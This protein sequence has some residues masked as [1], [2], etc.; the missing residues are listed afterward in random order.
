MASGV[1]ATLSDLPTVPTLAD[2]KAMD[3]RPAS[4]DVAGFAEPGDGYEGTFQWFA[5]DTSPADDVLTIEFPDGRYKRMLGHEGSVDPVWWIAAGLSPGAAMPAALATGNSVEVPAG[6]FKITASIVLS[7]PGQMFRGQ[8]ADTILE[9]EGDFDLF[10][11]T[12]NVEGCEVGDFRID[13]AD[14]S[15]GYLFAIRTAHRVLVENIEGYVGWSGLYVEGANFTTFREV[16]IFGLFGE[17]MIQ[18]Y[19]TPTLRSDVI[20]FDNVVISAMPFI[21]PEERPWGF[22]H[23]GNVHTVD[24]DALRMVNPRR[25]V[26][27]RATAPGTSVNDGTAPSFWAV[28]NVQ[29]DFPTY[30]GFYAEIGWALKI[31]SSYFSNSLMTENVYV[32]PGVLMGSLI[33]GD[34][35]GAAK[36]GIVIGAKDFQILGVTVAGNSWGPGSYGKHA[37]VR[38]VGSARRVSFAG[39]KSGRYDTVGA[40][41]SIGLDIELGAEEIKWVGGNLA[42]NLVPWRDRSGNDTNSIDAAGSKHSLIQGV[43]IS[44]E[45]GLGA[46][47]EPVVTGGAIPTVNVTYGGLK[48]D[49]A[50]PPVPFAMDFSAEPGAGWA[51]HVVIS[52]AGVITAVVTDTPGEGYDPDNTVIGLNHIGGLPIVQPH[53]NDAQATIAASGVGGVLLK[54]GRGTLAQ[55]ANL[56]DSVNYWQLIGTQDGAP[57]ILSAEGPGDFVS[58]SINLKGFGAFFIVNAQG[59]LGEW[60]NFPGSVEHIQQIGGPGGL[61][62]ATLTV[63]SPNADAVLKVKSK[64]AALLDLGLK[65]EGT[66]GAA[67]GTFGRLQ[68]D[69]VP[70]KVALLADS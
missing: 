20:T 22:I 49:P 4:V 38:V 31:S 63:S 62:P 65:I 11:F 45:I 67:T 25:G 29:V 14:H 2:L 10:I 34:V 21:P 47:L 64:G 39:V 5:G 30:Q 19:G 32:G 40:T 43:L 17:C 18:A 26:W 54:N 33:G 50:H 61:F 15:G 6:R 23:D 16:F 60:L 28:N 42:G 46:T 12:G 3:Y 48:Y 51:G 24:G 55:F 52:A 37:G 44:R 35:L 56:P 70:Y 68:I 36:E 58:G 13:G 66:A 59:T 9:I 69:G 53:A 1:L 7:N 57:A 27:V 8:G 41:Q